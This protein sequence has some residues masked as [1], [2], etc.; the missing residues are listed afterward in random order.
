MV[1]SRL[2]VPEQI[3]PFAVESELGRGGMGVVYLATQAGLNRKVA[4]KVLG[5]DYY[6]DPEFVERFH[7]EASVLA[8]MDSPHIIAIYEHGSS[9]GI[10]Y[11]ATQ[12]VT[13]RDLGAYVRAHG[14]MPVDRAL[15]VLAQI[16]EGLRDAHAKGVIHR[17]VKPGNVL[18][19]GDRDEPYAYLCDFGIAVSHT[20]SRNTRP[21]NVVGSSAYMAPER[22]LG[23]A[24]TASSDLYAAGCILWVLLTGQ[25]PYT[26]TEL[27]QALGHTQGPIPQLSGTDPVTT[28][29]NGLLARTLAK[30]PGERPPD[31]IDLLREVHA[32]AA[33]LASD[34]QTRVRAMAAAA[35]PRRRLTAPSQPASMLAPNEAP[36]SAAARATLEATLPRSA[37]QSLGPAGVI[38]LAPPATSVHSHKRGGWFAPT[39]IS[40]ASIAMAVAVFSVVKPPGEPTQVAAVASS[41]LPTTAQPSTEVVSYTC[42]DGRKTTALSS[43]ARP[44][45]EAQ[46]IAY[47]HYVYPNHETIAR[48][49]STHVSKTNSLTNRKYRAMSL[50]RQCFAGDTRVV[51]R[52]WKNGSDAHS[53]YDTRFQANPEDARSLTIGGKAVGGQTM[54]T[55]HSDRNQANLVAVWDEG[56]L[57]VSIYADDS[58]AL[59][60]TLR[61]MEAVIPSQVVGYPTSDGEPTT[62]AMGES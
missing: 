62:A 41:G 2:G 58:K 32:L 4:L 34:G 33:K 22:H 30:D 5:K 43:C 55:R 11:L 19:R 47:L 60:S 29:L 37:S 12:Y 26:G 24:A 13:G 7:R 56:H 20:A 61:R 16:L 54:Q 45:T 52:Y 25:T 10:L 49:C 1:L 39:A 35:T 38:P 8:S 27:Q 23:H 53:L 36:D 31:A 9:D 42:W 46:A 15:S 44:S 18:L 59:S 21:G 57:V 48:D 50:Y 40:L 6:D 17:D 51:T 3:G 28:G 14:P